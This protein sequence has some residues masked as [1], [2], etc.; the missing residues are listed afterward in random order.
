MGIL[1]L[2]ATERIC[3]TLCGPKKMFCSFARLKKVCCDHCDWKRIHC[4]FAR[5]KQLARLCT[6]QKRY[7]ETNAAQKRERCDFARPKKNILG[8]WAS[9]KYNVATCAT[10]MFCATL[11]Y[12]GRSLQPM[13]R[14]TRHRLDMLRLA[15]HKVS[16]P[17]SFRLYVSTSA[18]KN[19][20]V[21]TGAKNINL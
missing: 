3:V 1:R 18:T 12:P 21:S 16:I 14:P 8:L 15:L 4:N 9:H 19:A 17:G 11:R 2:C 13:F 5:L 10:T 7:V 6:T 20:Y